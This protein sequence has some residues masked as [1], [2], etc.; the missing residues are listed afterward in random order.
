MCGCEASET[1]GDGVVAGT[2]SHKQIL[3]KSSGYQ[4]LLLTTLSVP[5]HN[6]PAAGQLR[7]VMQKL[8]GMS[9][10]SEVPKRKKKKKIRPV[11]DLGPHMKVVI[12]AG[13]T[14]KNRKIRSH[15]QKKKKKLNLSHFCVSK[16]HLLSSLGSHIYL[17]VLKTPFIIFLL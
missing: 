6:S 7:R 17:L 2:A 3:F 15:E 13:H 9:V 16:K 12:C 1:R 4:G 11:S 5:P 8:H 14:A 10:H